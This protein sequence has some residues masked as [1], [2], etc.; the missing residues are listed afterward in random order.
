MKRLT[1]LITTLLWLG[2]FSDVAHQ[3]TESNLLAIIGAT[4]IDG[5]G[6]EP[7][8][9]T[10]I[11]RGERIEAV[12]SPETKPPTNARI[13]N[14]EGLT[15][16]PGIFDLHTHLPYASGGGVTGDWPK[17]LKAYLY[18]GVTSV[19]DFGTYPETFE[20][21]RRLI[22]TGIVE[23]PRISM[24]ARMTTP[25]GHG[26]EGGRG[27]FFSLEVSTP[28]EARAAVRRV[29]PY[30]PDAI[31]IFTDGWRYG[32]AADMTSM[33]EETLTALVDEAHKNGIEVLTH[34][35][36][37]DKAKIAARAK[38]DVIAHGIGDRDADEELFKAMKASST[39]YA[40]TLAVYEP[41]GR[42]ILTPLLDAMLEP[43]VKNGINPPLVAPQNPPL[44][45]AAGSAENGDAPRVRR[46]AT[47]QRN[48]A[49]LRKAG[50]TFGTGTDAGVSGTHHGWATL[51]EL[52]LLVA[53][54]LTPLEAITSAT[55]NAAQAIKVDDERGT[56]AAGKLADLILIAGE[57]HKTIGDIEKI[58]RVFLGGRELDREKLAREIASTT[59]SAIP[60]IKAQELVDDFERADG[61]SRL[62]TLWVNSSDAGVDPSK[63]VFG[64]VLRGEGNY[65]LSVSSRMSEKERPFARA[66]IPLSRG[67]IEPVDARAF[68]GVQFDVRG[69]GDYRLVVPIY[70]T[71]SVSSH[72]SVPFTAKPQWQTVKLDFV[73]FKQS[74]ARSP[75]QWTGADLLMLSFEVARPAGSLG[76]LELDDIKFYR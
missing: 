11:I 1:L 59:L 67:A 14:A 8:K 37:L 74:G 52:Q 39:T 3:Q 51:R 30:Q 10:V 33:N 64:R 65:A 49:A 40:P 34:T 26:A 24:A 4:V 38:V 57:P 25:G 23:A 45:P 60:A 73:S 69:D 18:C 75:A 28:R 16:M 29:L 61:R 9:Q 72:F 44:R 19:V 54:G 13:I 68:R 22:R 27:D 6:A 35:V 7:K 5:T 31:K 70:N 62:N 2:L 42:D 53:G 32:A 58:S 12:T 47:L 17:N 71:R 48:T 21:M 50:I 20:P 41:R 76:W 43:A 36:S 46:W 66:N 15:L 55:G 56:I 63:I